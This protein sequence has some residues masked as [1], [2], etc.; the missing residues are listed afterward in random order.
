VYLHPLRLLRLIR[1][2]PGAAP[3]PQPGR[4]R[5]PAQR[6]AH[7]ARAAAS[8]AGAPALEKYFLPH[9]I[10]WLFVIRCSLSRWIGSLEPPVTWFS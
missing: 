8:A 6:P 7:G 2:Y 5:P 4:A 3:A 10:G 9:R 1:Y